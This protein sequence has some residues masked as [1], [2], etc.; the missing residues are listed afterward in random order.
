MIFDHLIS[1]NGKRIEIDSNRDLSEAENAGK[2]A[3]T[4]LKEMFTNDETRTD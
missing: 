3:A 4:T 1:E 2:K